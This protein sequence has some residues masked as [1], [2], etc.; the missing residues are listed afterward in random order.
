M[1]R[2]NI[3]RETAMILVVAGMV[4][5]VGCSRQPIE[6]E[7]PVVPKKT[8]GTAKTT[9]SPANPGATTQPGK[10]S[11]QPSVSQAA[12]DASSLADLEASYVSKADVGSKMEIIAK[13]CEIGGA[14]AVTA[15][16]QLFQTENDPAVRQ[17]M[18]TSL[19]EVDGQDEAKIVLLSI[20]VA[21]AQPPEVRQEA[22][23]ALV[24]VEPKLA[25]PLLKALLNDSNEDIRDAAKNS[26][27]LLE[28]IANSLK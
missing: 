13:I 1:M 7:Q 24:D 11:S 17:E 27:E 23:S 9:P 28:A 20:A 6:D 16:G 14:S 18:L 22:I 15:V 26:I 19:Y 2:K 8:T 21:P 10:T 25:L 3:V 4:S 12:A 5:V